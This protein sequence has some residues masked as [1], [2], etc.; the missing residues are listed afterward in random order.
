MTS[1]FG[2]CSPGTVEADQMPKY[3]SVD[4]DTVSVEHIMAEINRKNINFTAIVITNST[5]LVALIP[6]KKNIYLTYV[7]HFGFTH[8][9]TSSLFPTLLCGII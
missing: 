5:L 3:C 7:F 6:P 1:S 9:C 4:G 8:M 2:S